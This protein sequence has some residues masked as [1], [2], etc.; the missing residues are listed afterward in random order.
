MDQN[1]KRQLQTNQI[2]ITPAFSRQHNTSIMQQLPHTWNTIH[3]L[4][5]NDAAC[6]RHV[7]ETNQP[8]INKQTEDENVY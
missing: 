2:R 8:C 7:R 6:K 5:M 3:N 4:N 1:A